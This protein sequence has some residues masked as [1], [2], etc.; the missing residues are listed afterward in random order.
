M[1]EPHDKLDDFKAYQK[2]CQ[3]FELA[4][5]DFEPLARNPA[6]VRLV[7]QQIA[8]ADSVGANM[9]EGFGRESKK[10][11]ALFLGYARGSTREVRGRY[12]RCAR[13]LPP[14]VVSSRVALCSEIIAILIRTIRRLRH[15]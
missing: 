14:D 11:F 1:G 3:L 13:W 4:A 5:D 10:E 12:E 6:L 9:E 2:A 7:S 15:G 8:A